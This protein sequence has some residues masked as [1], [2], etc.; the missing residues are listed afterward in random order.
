MKVNVY[1]S[2]LPKKPLLTVVTGKK[3]YENPKINAAILDFVEKIK[4]IEVTLR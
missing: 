1:V 4:Q 3:T 2:N